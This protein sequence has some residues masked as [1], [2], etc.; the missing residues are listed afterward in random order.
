MDAFST[1]SGADLGDLRMG[2]AKAMG[3]PSAEN[4][5]NLVAAIETLGDSEI[6]HSSDE[7]RP[8]LLML[9]EQ[10]LYLKNVDRGTK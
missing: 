6:L 5:K 3:D 8:Y 2:V 7:T 9:Q 1:V 4:L 10:A